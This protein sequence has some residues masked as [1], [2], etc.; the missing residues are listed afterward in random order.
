MTAE[1]QYTDDEVQ[2]SGDNKVER[3]VNFVHTQV[4]LGMDKNERTFVR[5]NDEAG[6]PT[7]YPLNGQDFRNW[8]QYHA[9]QHGDVLKAEDLSEI[10]SQLNAYARFEGEKM[11]V[12]LRAAQVDENTV[13]LDCADDDN[14]RV[15]LAAGEVTILKF[16]SEVLFYQSPTQQPLTIPAAEGNWRALL[17]FL[18]MAEQEKLL[19]I[20]WLT[21][22]LAHPRG[23]SVGYPV[24]VVKG[25]QGA[26]KSFLCKSIVRGLVDPN[27]S[28]IQLFPKDPKDLVISSQ[29]AHVLIYDNLRKL[30]KE[31]S[32]VLCIAAT[33]GTLSTR[34]LYTDSDENVMHLHAPVVLNGIHNFV[35]E[36]D[37]ASRCL[38]IQL[39]PM[40]AER[41]EHEAVL[42]T[43]LN[44]SLP[45]IF[46]G[47]LELAAKGLQIA[48]QTEVI[49]PER[50]LGYVRWLAAL[51]QIMELPAGELQLAYRH[52]LSQTMLDTI[53]ENL[54]AYTVLKFAKNYIDV[55]WQGRPQD[56]LT[57]LE[58]HAP[59]RLRSHTSQWPQNAISLSKRLSALHKALT[60]QGVKL[61]L[62][63]RGK[64]RQI[65][66]GYEPPENS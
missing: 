17:P 13:E 2:Y 20:G 32:D 60:A 1:P 44:N 43:R 21:Y 18:N 12:H 46:R 38:N 52:N 9:Y 22:I 53:Q 33:Q 42:E 58:A 15:R 50:M 35:E 64:H 39:H 31:W 27:L 48:D 54:L 55:P 59:R 40:D 25:E 3:S 24:L 29:N 41:R 8:L 63:E 14:I 51:E 47:L 30:T 36:P 19:F 6:N 56:L 16:G 10:Q 37:L 23:K 34:K 4:T 61:Q 57:T 66:I 28:G 45:S 62:G 65:T 49:H 11:V 26:G 7:C 5:L